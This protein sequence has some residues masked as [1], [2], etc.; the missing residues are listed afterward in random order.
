VAPEISVVVVAGRRRDR[1]REVAE[2]VRAQ[3]GVARLELLIADLEPGAAAI[4]A[5]DLRVDCGGLSYG[6]AR[7]RATHRASA[8]IVAFLEDHCLPTPGWSDTLVEAYNGGPWVAVGYGFE[9]DNP[10]HWVSRQSMMADYGWWQ[11]A[12][13]RGP[14]RALASNNVSYRRDTL[15]ACGDELE[16]L[17]A[18]D[19]LLHERLARRG[20]A[21]FW[22]CRATVRHRNATR[23][24]HVLGA[25][26]AYARVH[27]A[28]RA[29][30]GGWSRRRRA[31]YGLVV[32]PLSPALRIARFGRAIGV[33]TEAWRA[34]LPALPFVGLTY[35]VSA[36]GSG[37]GYLVGLGD[38]EAHFDRWETL[39]ERESSA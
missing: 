28:R 32:S 17:L 35:G 11:Y 24:D 6:A 14:V 15:L 36:S 2:A 12:A 13:E 29:H 31:F 26:L 19:Q 27:A 37:I 9:N 4:E 38:A 20:D 21:L 30:V 1:A 33:K 18:P 16:T 34:F 39:S 22:E 10:E 8:P 23:I 5:V 3:A 25:N 7:A